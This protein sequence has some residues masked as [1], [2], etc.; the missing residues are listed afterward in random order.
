MSVK[1][2]G[3]DLA[4]SYIDAGYWVLPVKPNRKEPYTQLAY[5][6]YLSATDDHNVLQD[7]IDFDPDM[8]IGISCEASGIIVF[9]VDYRNMTADSWSAVKH[10][11]WSDTHIVT[12]G[13]G[14]HIYYKCPQELKVRGKL[15][16]GVDIKYRG[17]VLAPPSL[18]PSGASYESNNQQIID[19]P[20]YLLKEIT[21]AVR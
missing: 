9:D 2:S 18:H 21:N 11:V 7:W 13:N 16:D 10:F 14:V 1:L 17:Y 8:N 15:Y 12:T 5:R 6:G 19:I 3:L 4:H 20:D